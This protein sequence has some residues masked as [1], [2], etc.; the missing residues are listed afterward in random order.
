MPK[1]SLLLWRLPRRVEVTVSAIK[2]I[3]IGSKHFRAHLSQFCP[4]I[5]GLVILRS[6]GLVR[7]WLLLILR[8]RASLNN[9]VIEYR[10]YRQ[11]IDL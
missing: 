5:E 2:S 8:R 11:L 1:A 10:L 3:G 4:L 7:M 6:R 9:D